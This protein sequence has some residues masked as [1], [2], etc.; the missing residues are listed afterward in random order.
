MAAY[1]QTLSGVVRCGANAK[2]WLRPYEVSTTFSAVDPETAV[3]HTLW[4]EEDD[5]KLAGQ[6]RLKREH[7]DE[8]TA[9]IKA[10]GFKFVVW[11]RCKKGK[12]RPVKM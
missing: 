11:F 7:I 10:H 12:V 9:A 2:G 8:M 4:R 3:C 5:A 1:V 6:R